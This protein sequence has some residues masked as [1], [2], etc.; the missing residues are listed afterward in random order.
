MYSSIYSVTL[1]AYYCVRPDQYRP[2]NV[3]TRSSITETWAATVLAPLEDE[4]AAR[5]VS[6]AL[7][8]LA[9][10]GRDPSRLR[11][12]PPQLRIEKPTERDGTPRR[13]VRVQIGD[14]DKHLVYDISVDTDG[15]IAE[16]AAVEGVYPPVTADELGEARRVAESDPR[17]RKL[18]GDESVQVHVFAPEHGPSRNRRVG[19]VYLRPGHAEGKEGAAP[20]GPV[21]LGQV[22]VDLDDERIVS[23]AGAV[24]PEP[25]RAR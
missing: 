24:R 9:E 4:E 21:R 7:Q 11:R 23:F 15:R 19:I 18:I 22:E 2:E 20:F 5:A 6:L 8:S 1:C 13:F 25:K 14:R 12:Y 10:V 16:S 3:V 17:V